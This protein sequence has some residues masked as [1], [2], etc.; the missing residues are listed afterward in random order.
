MATL[1]PRLLVRGIE[2]VPGEIVDVVG[3]MPQSQNWHIRVGVANSGGSKA[4]II[5]SNLTFTKTN[6]FSDGFKIVLPTF[7]PY[8]K[9]RKSFGRFTVEAGEHTERM[10]QLDFDMT[11]RL[12]L[13]RTIRAG[14]GGAGNS[15]YCMGFF[16]YQ[17]TF[18]VT[19]RT[20]FSFRYDTETERF[21]R[22]DNSDYNYAD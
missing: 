13:Q 9:E 18:R 11:M 22:V 12:K 21:E 2:V 15:M 6:P 19:R 7:P 1:R 20:A 5:E 3:V 8:S 16:Q 10:V 14:G 17:D 4:R